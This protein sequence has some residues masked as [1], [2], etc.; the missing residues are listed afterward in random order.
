MNKLLLCLPLVLSGCSFLFTEQQR[1][2]HSSKN[3]KAELGI[4]KAR[5]INIKKGN[6]YYS[7]KLSCLGNYFYG[8][9]KQFFETADGKTN[10]QSLIRFTVAPIYDKT[11]KVYPARST[12]LSEL[13]INALSKIKG[14]SIVEI[15]LGYDLYQ[16]RN[17][18]G[19][20]GNSLP[21]GPNAPFFSGVQKPP[22]GVLFPTQYY[23]SGALVQYDERNETGNKDLAANLKYVTAKR[24][25]EKITVGIQLRLV[26]AASGK[27]TINPQTNLPNS[28]YLKNDLWKIANGINFFRIISSSPWGVDYSV[29]TSDPL[30]YSVNEIIERGVYDLFKTVASLTPEQG[31]ECDNAE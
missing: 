4:Q 23:I 25:I 17:N 22:A 18:F 16:S 5:V 15:P 14:L 6:T 24:D 19:L 7:K 10:Y 20:T 1:L 21:Y 2:I 3:E 9:N 30:Q 13:V 31:K 29:E 12:A 11:A 27:V 8:N 26:D 28:I